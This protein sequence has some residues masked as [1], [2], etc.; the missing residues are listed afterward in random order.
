MP[1]ASGRNEV[2]INNPTS[3]GA[4]PAA[5]RAA[6][7]VVRPASAPIA[8]SAAAADA[9]EMRALVAGQSFHL[10]I[11]DIAMPGSGTGGDD[12]RVGTVREIKV[13]VGDEVRHDDVILTLDVSG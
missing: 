10:A 9:A 13:E 2:Q 1:W 11:L 12:M 5:S 7:I 6:R 3:S 8:P 4:R